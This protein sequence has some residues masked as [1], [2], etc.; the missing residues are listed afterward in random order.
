MIEIEEFIDTCSKY[1][2]IQLEKEAILLEAEID[3]RKVSYNTFI[4]GVLLVGMLK[5]VDI[6]FGVLKKYMIYGVNILEKQQIILNGILFLVWGII[7]IFLVFA[8]VIIKSD[9]SNSKKKK[10][11]LLII[12]REL[13]MRK[14]D[15]R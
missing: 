4:I 3:I 5:L 2:Y 14:N 7:I 10:Q 1:E 15:N 9:M 13:E 11:K 6:M 8:I 12:K